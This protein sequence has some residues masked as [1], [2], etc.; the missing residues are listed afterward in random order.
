MRYRLFAAVML[1]AG[2]AFVTA[3]QAADSPRIGVV[4]LQQVIG[5][6]HRGQAAN[7]KFNE[8]VQQIRSEAQ[9][10]RKKL[11]VLEGQ[12]KKAAPK[13]KEYASLQ[14][15]YQDEANSYQQFLSDSQNKLDQ[16]KQD[17]LQPIEVELQK[18]MLAYAKDHQY[19]ILINKN[20]AGA[21]FAT[22]KYDLTSEIT[23][24]MDKDWEEMQKT[25][26]KPDKQ[27]K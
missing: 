27:G 7:V 11:S 5:N 14:K 24:A 1:A 3:A 18:V 6:S 2:L 25:A 19:D 15:N 21:L 12:I 26:P 10:R 8:L 20:N 4:D 9:D 13:S 16:N 23:E 17:L 22:D